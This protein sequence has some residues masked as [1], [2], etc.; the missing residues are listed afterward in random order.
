MEKKVLGRVI[1]GVGGLYTVLVDRDG[2]ELAAKTV[3][4][5]ARGALRRGGSSVLAGDVVT[6]SYDADRYDGTH[7]G[8]EASFVI[9]EIGERKNSLIRPPLSN[10]D[11]LF[12]TVAAA[13]PAPVLLTVDKLFSICVYNDIEPIAL[14]SKS[15]LNESVAAEIA[16]IYKKAGFE[17]FITSAETGEGIDALSSYI[18]KLP[19]GSVSA[20]SGASGVG[21]STL[22]NKLF[23][24]LELST[25]SVSRKTERGRHTTRQTELFVIREGDVK[26]ENPVFLADTPGFTMLDF[27][28]FDFFSLEDLP[29]TMRE[30]EAHIGCCKYKKCTH[31]KEEGCSILEAVASGEISPSRH[32][33]YLA[34]YETLKAKKKW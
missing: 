1:K 11:Y 22:L 5:R 23:P 14:I 26:G 24:H 8:D 29:M 16:E 30:F 32:K 28:Q 20:F 17:T 13:S 21:K 6:L 4:S 18:D 12:I 19:S 33:S 3:Q 9:E 27:D 31:T 10:L 25:S 34:L 15:E 2:G 7:T